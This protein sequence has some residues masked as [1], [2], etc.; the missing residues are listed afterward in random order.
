MVAL[1]S[2][3]LHRLAGTGAM[4]SVLLPHEE[5]AARLG[6][7]AGRVSVAAVNGP[8]STVVSGD[9]D[10]VDALLDRLA[11]KGAQVRRIAASVA[12]HSAHIDALRAD[13]DKAFADVEPRA[14]G[15]AFCSSVTGGPLPTDAL[16]ASYWHRN[17]RQTVR[18]E[19]A[20]RALLER[21]HRVFVELGPHP[22]L[23]LSLEE[24]AAAVDREVVA[25]GSLRRGEGGLDRFV[26]GAAEAHAHGAALDW[27]AAA[28]GGRRVDLPTYAWQG[29]RY[30]LAP[31]TG[32]GD[33]AAAGAADA[34]HP[35]LGAQV[36]LPDGGLVLTGRLSLRDQPWL[37]DHAVAGTA[38][39]PGAGLLELALRAGAAA[40]CA[41]VEELTLHTPLVLPERGG[42]QLRVVAEPPGPDGRLGVG[43]HTRHGDDE[44]WTA[45]ADGLLAPAPDEPDRPAPAGPWP[46]EGAEPVV[47]DGA[48]ERL[49]EAGYGYGPAFRGLAAVWRR[50]TETYAEV[51]LAEGQRA[52]AQR[53]GL[54]PAA[55]DAALHAAAAGRTDSGVRLPF[56][57][58]GVSLH[59]AGASELRVRLE[60]RGD[61][62]MSVTLTDP[63]GTPVLTARS[64]VTRPVDPD[65][66]RRARD[67][68]DTARDWLYEV[69]WPPLPPSAAPGVAVGQWAVLAG[70]ADGGDAGP[71]QGLAEAL[72]TAGAPAG[73][74]QDLAEL[75]AA[76]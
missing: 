51:R 9:P 64:L 11:G 33:L 63:A 24:T 20:A 54:H 59:A 13:L 15:T 43:V 52:D 70:P 58:S 72:Q 22:V 6:P 28:P 73:V 42:V 62:A 39:L 50:G 31:G 5:V 16:D 35:L 34:R 66:V 23:A 30:W 26:A 61:D 60:S 10:A 74:Y 2:Q 69:A 55:L 7:W 53:F 21:G 68:T 65:A 14:V 67:R 45:H 18:F 46:P 76:V 75:A 41:R 49:A 8:G 4:A 36:P 32:A 38:L 27:A 3:A 1:R 25:L 12:G 47:L 48:Y 17:V 57:W 29:A 71:G 19:Q 56:S 40:G 44:P 37:A